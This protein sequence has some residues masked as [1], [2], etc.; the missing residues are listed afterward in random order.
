[1]LD[2]TEPGERRVGAAAPVRR[3]AGVGVRGR[4]LLAAVV[5]AAVVWLASGELAWPARAYLVVLLA[6]LPPIAVAQAS[7]IELEATSLPRI[8]VYLSSLAGLWFLGVLAL[9]AGLWSGFGPGELG[10][11]PLGA[12]D[13]AVW[14]AGALG[15]AVGLAVVWRV[16]G[17]RESPVLEALLPRT[18]VEKAFFV[19]LSLSA[20]VCE[21]LVFRGFLI[22]AL[23]VAAS[24]K[25][26]AVALSAGVFGMVHAYQRV[27][28]IVRAGLLG[29]VLTVPVLGTGSLVPSML[30]HFIYDV[31]AGLWLA[32]WLM[33]R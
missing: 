20:G 15:G 1:M 23:E 9:G 32:G 29:L 2:E 14:T 27:A 12:R 22:G 25:W 8:P 16:F 26:L 5:A 6:L 30:A 13:V 31:V 17:V 21:E 11:V 7:V 28:G 10:L 18:G 19:A 4:V 3:R 33:R 24:S